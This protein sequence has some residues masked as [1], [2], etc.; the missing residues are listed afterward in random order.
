MVHVTLVQSAL[1]WMKSTQTVIT[2]SQDSGNRDFSGC[3][4]CFT[5][6]DCLKSRAKQPPGK[7][8][9]KLSGVWL[10]NKIK[11]SPGSMQFRFISSSVWMQQEKWNSQHHSGSNGSKGGL[12]AVNG[13]LQICRGF[14]GLLLLPPSSRLLPRVPMCLQMVVPEH[15][16]SPMTHKTHV[17][18]KKG[19]ELL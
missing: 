15:Q 18:G 3:C 9:K 5:L 6:H 7:K 12:W 16:P 17:H 4:C 2:T 19:C 10:S 1:E 13:V 14:V 11:F 8:K